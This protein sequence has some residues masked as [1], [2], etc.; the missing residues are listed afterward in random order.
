MTTPNQDIRRGSP[1]RRS[2]R[3]ASFWRHPVA[4]VAPHEWMGTASGRSVRE[5]RHWLGHP[6]GTPVGAPLPDTCSCPAG[7]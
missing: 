4:P 7:G 1:A 6:P 5:S 3:P 2:G